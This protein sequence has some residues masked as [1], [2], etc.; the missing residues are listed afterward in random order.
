MKYTK[1]IGI[2]LGELLRE[3]KITQK[4]LAEQCQISRVTINRTIKGHVKAVTF[5]TLLAVCKVLKISW[6][7][8]F[9]VDIFEI[10]NLERDD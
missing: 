6:K 7:D 3:R 8:F 5:E 10:S 1:A 2:R 9:D 4:A